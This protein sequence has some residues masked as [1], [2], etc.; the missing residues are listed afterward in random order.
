MIFFASNLHYLRTRTKK[1]QQ[2]V[3]DDLSCG[4]ETVKGWENGHFIPREPNMKKI[5][6][7]YDV[8]VQDLTHKDLMLKYRHLY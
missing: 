6:E 7:Y 2:E 4:R 5:A 3:A 8:S 1:S